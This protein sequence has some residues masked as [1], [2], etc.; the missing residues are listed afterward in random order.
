MGLVDALQNLDLVLFPFLLKPADGLF[1]G[2]V[3]PHEG[4][5]LG[6]QLRHFGLDPGQVFRGEGF[7]GV[8]VVVKTRFDGRADGHLDAGEQGPHRLGHEVGGAVAHD[9]EALGAVHPDGGQ[10]GVLG[11]EGGEIH[12]IAVY[13]GG[14]HLVVGA[15]PQFF[16]GLGYGDAGGEIPAGAFGKGNFH[17]G[18]T[19]KKGIFGNPRGRQDA[20][21]VIRSNPYRRVL[22]S[23][24]AHWKLSI[25]YYNREYSA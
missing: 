2:D 19:N 1:S 23:L 18:F 9:L 7:L 10:G 4:K 17:Y 24:F 15:H 3:L 11:E 25:S 21:S 14:H 12:G 16:Q 6:H 8:E 5:V 13:S 20:T 22:P